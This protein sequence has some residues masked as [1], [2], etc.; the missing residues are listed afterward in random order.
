MQHCAGKEIKQLCAFQISAPGGVQR[1]DVLTDSSWVMDRRGEVSG[2]AKDAGASV[3]AHYL[4]P[5]K[6]LS[7]SA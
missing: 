1:E 3:R 5:T 4:P 2:K 7:V 6:A